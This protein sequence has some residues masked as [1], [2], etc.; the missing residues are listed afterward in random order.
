MLSAGSDSGESGTGGGQ[1]AGTGAQIAVAALIAA[2][3]MALGSVLV[4]RRHTA[5]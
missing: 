1:L 3:L 4:R 5:S 2:A